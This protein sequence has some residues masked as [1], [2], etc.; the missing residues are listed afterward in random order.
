[1]KDEFG[2]EAPY[3]FK[4]I[5]FPRLNGDIYCDRNLIGAYFFY[6]YKIFKYS[7]YPNNYIPCIPLNLI[8]DE[9]DPQIIS[10]G[11]VTYF[12]TFNAENFIIYNNIIKPSYDIKGKQILNDIVFCAAEV[13]DNYID[14]NCY[15]L[16]IY[17]DFVREN[18]FGKNNKYI[19]ICGCETSSNHN[20]FGNYNS[21][22]YV[23]DL[24]ST[25]IDNSNKLLFLDGI[26]GSHICSN[27]YNCQFIGDLYR[28]KV[29]NNVC[30]VTY[31]NNIYVMNKEME[32]ITLKNLY[33]TDLTKKD[34][35]FDDITK[36]LYNCGTIDDDMI[37]KI[38]ANIDGKV[39]YIDDNYIY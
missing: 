2:N 38:I 7:G 37:I 14:S 39:T 6:N 36:M 4:N 10:D 33:I 15:G 12:Y 26:T 23:C 29:G 13:Y 19:V 9:V 21:H 16:S 28:L 24:Q 27:S 32:L 20:I 25:T 17:G 11:F 34:N 5:M 1:M 3:D 30:N 8:N 31:N 18:T 35:D 22:I